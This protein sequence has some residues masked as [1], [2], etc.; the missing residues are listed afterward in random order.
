VRVFGGIGSGGVP[1]PNRPRRIN[2]LSSEDSLLAVDLK[3]RLEGDL[4]R[5]LAVSL[6]YDHPTLEA[7]ADHLS[8][9]E[10]DSALLAE[11]EA[12]SED[13]AALLLRDGAHG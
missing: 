2:P 3:N 11:I 1:A 4:A 10:S 12:L 13:E 8:A 5:P 6:V 7:L 9:E